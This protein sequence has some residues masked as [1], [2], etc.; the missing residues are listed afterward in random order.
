ML[1][2]SVVGSRT[3]S[4]VVLP[5]VVSICP[6]MTYISTVHTVLLGLI[7]GLLKFISSSPPV[8]LPCIPKPARKC[9]ASMMAGLCLVAGAGFLQRLEQAAVGLLRTADAHRHRVRRR[10]L[11]DA[12][13]HHHEPSRPSRL[14]PGTGLAVLEKYSLVPQFSRYGREQPIA[15]IIGGVSALPCFLRPVKRILLLEPAPTLAP[16][17][18]PTPALIR[19]LAPIPK[20]IPTP[21]PTPTLIQTL[22]RTLRP[23]SDTDTDSGTETNS[24]TDSVADTDS[25]TNTDNVP[26]DPR[27][28]E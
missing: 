1:Q 22:I 13:G 7:L 9:V 2:L 5:T 6:Q 28:T 24:R 14:L 10:G 27:Y 3:H 8:A 26:S 11:H 20:P 16:T 21:I 18:I 25:D 15:E 17:P 19:T 23:I 12:S 4:A